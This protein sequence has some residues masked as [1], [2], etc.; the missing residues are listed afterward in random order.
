MISTP[1]FV[2]ILFALP[3]AFS[4]VPSCSTTVNPVTFEHMPITEV[5]FRYLGKNTVKEE[6]LRTLIQTRTGNNYAQDTVDSDIR[7]LYSSGL[8]DDVAFYAEPDTS[9]VQISIE[10]TTRP[11]IEIGSMN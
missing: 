9:G 1:R 6:R 3:V 7:A 5:T 4:A 10:I 2:I 11:L 8:V